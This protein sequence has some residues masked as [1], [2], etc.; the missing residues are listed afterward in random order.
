MMTLI[1]MSDSDLKDTV[2][3]HAA[4][5]FIA[6]VLAGLGSIASLSATYLF[7]TWDRSENDLRKFEF[8]FKEWKT[9]ASRGND[10]IGLV[11]KTL[12]HS[13]DRR[14]RT[15]V[16]DLEKKSSNDLRAMCWSNLDGAMDDLA[17]VSGYSSETTGLPSKLH[18]NTQAMLKSEVEY[19]RY[20]GRIV[21]SLDAGKKLSRAALEDWQARDQDAMFTVHVYGSSLNDALSLRDLQQQVLDQQREEF[22]AESRHLYRWRLAALFGIF[23]TILGFTLMLRLIGLAR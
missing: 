3:Q 1:P 21:D 18:E 23:A 22:L 12:A 9:K 5:T 19:W 13:T 7:T 10:F 4:L 15:T 8:A 16:S 6:L 20:C 11:T 17:V 14:K 2:R